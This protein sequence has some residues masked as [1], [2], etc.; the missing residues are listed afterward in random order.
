MLAAGFIFRDASGEPMSQ[1][2]GSR[3]QRWLTAWDTSW[4]DRAVTNGAQRS[5]AMLRRE[6]GVRSNEVIIVN[7]SL[8][9]TND[10]VLPISLESYHQMIGRGQPLGRGDFSHLRSDGYSSVDMSVLSGTALFA[11]WTGLATFGGSENARGGYWVKIRATEGAWEGWTISYAHMQEHIMTGT[12]V[13]VGMGELVG[14]SGDSGGVPPHLHLRLRSPSAMTVSPLV[15]FP[16]LAGLN[17]W[18]AP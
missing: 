14:Y 17:G 10:A 11:A 5:F 3:I 7:Q 16:W 1:S 18:Y 2:L 12:D 8:V 9:V 4:I 15:L 6:L 13:P